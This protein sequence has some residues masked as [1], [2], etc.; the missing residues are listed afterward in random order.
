MFLLS[1]SRLVA[2]AFH[3][4]AY[5][6][7]LEEV[8]RGLHVIEKLR[9]Y[10]PKAQHHNAQSNSGHGKFTLGFIRPFSEKD[11]N[12]RQCDDN[13]SES[14]DYGNVLGAEDHKGKGK[15]RPTS[16][17]PH[18]ITPDSVELEDLRTTT[19][20]SGLINPS[21]ERQDTSD[22]YLP[23]RKRAV[24]QHT[25][26]YEEN[27]PAIQAARVIKS[28][29]LHDARN[30]KG[31]DRELKG[32]AFSVNSAHEAKVHRNSLSSVID[33]SCRL[34]QR[35]ARA[36][37]KTLRERHRTYLISEDFQPAFATL[38][39]AQDAFRIFDKD[40]NGDISLPE[41]KAVILRVY[42]ER[43]SLSRSMRDVGVALRT[44]NQILLLFAFVI[45]FFISLSV[46][47]VNVT[48]SL[49]SMYSLAI[50]ASFIFKNAAS[51]MFD[52]IIFLF[53][54]QYV[55]PSYLDSFMLMFFEPIR[56]G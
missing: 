7:R 18:D 26:R 47:G 9:E 36:I 3:R 48:Q 34:L 11:P 49:T 5:K 55:H 29:V 53:V 2:F 37:Y 52:A 45:L 46:F 35:L 27:N 4:T 42:N 14:S 20:D 10:K 33:H 13:F 39:E 16:F 6:E 17:H 24:D 28:A 32:L 41:I 56:F 54:T 25:R 8:K 51:S 19:G 23:S 22:E 21:Y 31:S 50:A 12:H 30:I 1:S 38:A 43:R 44:L 15:H 40:N